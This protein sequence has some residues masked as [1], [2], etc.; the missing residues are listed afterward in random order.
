MTFPVRGAKSSRTEMLVSIARPALGAEE[1][2]AVVEVLRSGQLTQ[3]ERVAEFERAFAGFHRAEHGIATSSGTTALTAALLAHEI[4]AGDEVIVPSF[5]FFASAATVV[6]VGAKPVF[7]DIE[8]DTYCLSPDAAEAAITA[9]TRAIMAV[10]MY[11][12][13][14]DMVRL[15]ALCRARGL[16]LLEDVA[17]APGARIDGRPVGSFGTAAFSFHP[18]KNLTT[19]E[20]GMVLTRDAAVAQRLRMIR[21]QGRAVPHGPHELFGYNFRMSEVSAAIGAIQLGRLPEA[22]KRRRE[23]AAY[24]DRH[25]EGVGLPSVRPGS[26]HVYHQYTVRLPAGVERRSFLERLRV[27]GIEARV[28]YATPIH[29]EPAFERDGEYRSLS[30]P[31]T[32]RAC[33]EVVSLPVHPGLTLDEVARVARAA[34]S[35]CRA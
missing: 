29:R 8:P 5:S 23:H 22:Q 25:L 35:A 34:S 3:A 14:A 16:V 30:L 9:R 19:G 17:H 15:E 28:Y 2:A 27:D 18:S 21:S 26:E 20:G 1:I 33:R 7:V 12:H 6:G 4:G 13:P 10:H 31:E 11:G 24:L 32:E